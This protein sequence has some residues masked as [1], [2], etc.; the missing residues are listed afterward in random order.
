MQVHM[1]NNN[2]LQWSNNNVPDV[3][4]RAVY[5]P[6]VQRVRGAAAALVG[7]ARTARAAELTAAARAAGAHI[8]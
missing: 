5:L 7:R 2:D 4:P 6:A 1:I 8:R 3:V